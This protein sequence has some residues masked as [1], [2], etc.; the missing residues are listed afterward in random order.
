[1]CCE[2]A[3]ESAEW[4]EDLDPQSQSHSTQQSGA[5]GFGCVPTLGVMGYR[6]G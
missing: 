5:L 4:G 2:S 1:M 3:V 6:S